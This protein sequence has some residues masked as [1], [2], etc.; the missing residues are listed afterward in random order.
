MTCRRLVGREVAVGLPGRRGSPFA[1]A[2][3]PPDD[4]WTRG[5]RADERKSDGDARVRRRSSTAPASPPGR[6]PSRVASDARHAAWDGI[7]SS[8]DMR[9]GLGGI[10]PRGRAPLD[11][12]LDECTV[13]KE[14]VGA[15]LP[16][17]ARRLMVGS[18]ARAFA[19]SQH[20]LCAKKTVESASWPL[21]E[22]QVG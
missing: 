14:S 13:R 9:L 10:L 3:S 19:L 18:H 5:R 22:G 4:E 21:S 17:T 16:A 12:S 1:L 11:R 15:A 2:P 6:H 7:V 20:R 8:W